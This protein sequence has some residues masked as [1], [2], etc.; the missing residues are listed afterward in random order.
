MKP[1]R[2]A[3]PS[4]PPN[5]ISRRTALLALACL[6]VAVAGCGGGGSG[7]GDAASS[8]SRSLPQGFTLAYR[9]EPPGA[10]EGRDSSALAV[11]ADGTLL[12]TQLL[13]VPD[14]DDIDILPTPQEGVL[15]SLSDYGI[16]GQSVV[17]ELLRVPPSPGKYFDDLA[18]V[19]TAAGEIFVPGRLL[20]GPDDGGTPPFFALSPQG[21]GRRAVTGNLPANGMVE[22]PDGTFIGRSAAPDAGGREQIVRTD[23]RGNYLNTV[24]EAA[25]RD[26]R[27]QPGTR[28]FFIPLTPAVTSSGDVY[29]YC[30]YFTGYDLTS[31]REGFFAAKLDGSDARFIPVRKHGAFAHRAVRYDGAMFA[32]GEGNL[33]V[34]ALTL[35]RAPES[36]AAGVTSPAPQATPTPPTFQGDEYSDLGK[37]PRRAAVHKFAPD[38]ME[39]GAALLPPETSFEGG[40]AQRINAAVDVAGNI[41]AIS[42]RGA[43]HVY[44]RTR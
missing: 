33:Y 16:P 22:C 43:I 32:D 36:S 8:P 4:A 44:K 17:R 9:V 18:P 27:F 28:R 41:Y 20:A 7:G 26:Q 25:G 40:S 15:T 30:A 6:P 21:T 23:A 37:Y 11:M 19:V 34:E 1:C 3:P 24:M 5:P 14:D 2:P 29:M 31:E 42:D 13:P 35:D 39:L 38:G 10:P 12:L